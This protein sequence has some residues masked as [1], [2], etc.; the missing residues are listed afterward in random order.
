MEAYEIEILSQ[1]QPVRLLTG[2]TSSM[3][4]VAADE[5]ADF[6]GPQASL[7]VRIYQISETA[8]RGFPLAASLS[9]E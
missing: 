9:V 5:M 1:G 2:S 8:G 3:T 6:G 7:D 4:Y